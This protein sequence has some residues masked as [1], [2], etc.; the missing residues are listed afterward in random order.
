MP[1]PE[2]VDPNGWYPIDRLLDL[3]DRL[4]KAVSHYG[5]TSYGKNAI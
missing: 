1:T 5:H 2:S 4:D 3:I